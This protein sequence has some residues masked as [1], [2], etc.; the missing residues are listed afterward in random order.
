MYV[1]MTRAMDKLHLCYA[2]TRMRYG[3]TVAGRPSVFLTEL[4]RSAIK[5]V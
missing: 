5:L 2:A 4:P 3:Q 1:A